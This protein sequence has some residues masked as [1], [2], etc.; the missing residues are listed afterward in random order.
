MGFLGSYRM[1]KE[2]AERIGEER[3]RLREGEYSSTSFSHTEVT[4]L[5]LGLHMDAHM[6]SMKGFS[7]GGGVGRSED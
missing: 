7:E 4:L 1:W 3:Q 2:G 6:R 5:G